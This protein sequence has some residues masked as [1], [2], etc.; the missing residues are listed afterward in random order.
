MA[1]CRHVVI[2]YAGSSRLCAHLTITKC[3]IRPGSR[4]DFQQDQR[5]ASFS[6]L[7]GLSGDY[8]ELEPVDPVLRT[9]LLQ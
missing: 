2:G 1:S 9:L 8:T 5:C 6:A 4:S 7:T 3:T